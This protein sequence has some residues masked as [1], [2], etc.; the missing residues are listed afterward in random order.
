[1]I[2][3]VTMIAIIETISENA[4][5]IAIN[6]SIRM[7]CALCAAGIASI[8]IQSTPIATTTGMITKSFVLCKNQMIIVATE[9]GDRN[10]HDKARMRK[11]PKF[12]TDYFRKRMALY[13]HT[14]G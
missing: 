6:S 3:D 2:A 13:L 4:Q 8:T 14:V 12:Q 11:M 5:I 1:M 7:M 9:K 10:E